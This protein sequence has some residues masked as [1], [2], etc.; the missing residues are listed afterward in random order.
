MGAIF[1]KIRL[2]WEED[3]LPLTMYGEGRKVQT[4]VKTGMERKLR[5]VIAGVLALYPHAALET[6][7][8]LTELESNRDEWE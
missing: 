1:D 2:L 8:E 7:S 3:P 6:G 5:L 4:G